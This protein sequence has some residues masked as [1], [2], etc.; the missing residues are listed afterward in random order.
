MY[1]TPTWYIIY[2]SW[3]WDTEYILYKYILY[4]NICQYIM[5]PTTTCSPHTSASSNCRAKLYTCVCLCICIW[6]LREYIY[7]HISHAHT[8]THTHTHTHTHIHIHRLWRSPRTPTPTAKPTLTHLGVLNLARDLI[9]S[10]L[11]N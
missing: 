1:P 3:V 6:T 2:Y 7:I 5:Y 8:Y 10:C 9:N 11:T 4:P